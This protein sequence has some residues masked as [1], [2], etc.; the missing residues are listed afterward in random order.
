MIIAKYFMTSS[1]AAKKKI[2][3]IVYKGQT[4]DR[5]ICYGCLGENAFNIN[6]ISTINY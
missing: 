5:S 2:Y 6:T 3:S 4:V 1:N